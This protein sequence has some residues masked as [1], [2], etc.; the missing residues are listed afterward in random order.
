MSDPTPSIPE[1]RL[2]IVRPDLALPLTAVPPAAVPPERASFALKVRRLRGELRAWRKAGLPLASPALREERR[3]ACE[4][5]PYFAP[6]GN[7]GLGECHAPGCGCTR[8][9]RWLLTSQCKH[10]DGSRWPSATT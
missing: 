6:A 7:L 5:C 1:G 3:A 4:A 8:M 10:P 2:Y 9:K